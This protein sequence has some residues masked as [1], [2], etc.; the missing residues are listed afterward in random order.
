MKTKSLSNKVLHLDTTFKAQAT[1]EDNGTVKIVGYASTNDLD[2]AG[3][4]ILPEA[5]T[6]S[7]GLDN[8]KKN[9]IIL[10]NH[11]Y[12]KPIGR[13]TAVS[14]TDKGLSIEATISKA[15]GEVVELIKDGVLNAFSVGFMIKDANYDSASDIFVIK[16]AELYETSVVSVPC[17][18]DATFSLAKAFDSEDDFNDYKK[19]FIK[20][21]EPTAEDLAN[22]QNLA[23]KQAEEITPIKENTM[24]PKELEIMLQKVATET[25]EALTKSQAEAA[26]KLAEEKAATEK[27][28]ET[29]NIKVTS[30]AEKLMT[31]I[32]TRFNEKNES[33]ESI[34]SELKEELSAKSEEIVAMRE[35]K[36]EFSDRSGSTDWKKA[37]TEEA[38]DN[39]ILG[40]ATGKGWKTDTAKQ[41]M[42]KVN[43]DSGVEVSSEDFE[44]IVSTN[45]QRD[46]EL[47]LVIAPMF[48]ELPMTS[49]T[50]IMPIMPDAG[51]AEFVSATTTSAAPP[52][53][54]LDE[55][56]VAYGTNAGVDLQER[57][58]S[59]K[60]LMSL[61]YLG[62]ETEEDAILPILPLIREAMVR[63]HA[64]AIENAVL[65]GNHA[66]GAFGTAGASF[67]G[68]VALADADAHQTAISTAFASN[69]VTAA[70]LM[71]MR[72]GMGKYGMRPEDVTYIVSQDAYFDL[73]EDAEF[74]DVNLVGS[75]AVKL[76]GSVGQVYGSSVIVCPE[77]APKALNT[78][79]ALAV[80]TRNFVM[81]RLRGMTIESEYQTVE[82]RRAL[83][84][85][86][87]IGFIDVIDGASAKW[88]L[89]YAAS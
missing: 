57:V 7:K 75:Q 74:A 63:S 48:R 8:F 81:P 79:C 39:F 55:R 23:G 45:I 50:M 84:A 69:V 40:L 80:N 82:Q 34:V 14:V 28:E 19:E 60:K 54:N 58:V 22:A 20:P 36:R 83:V 85:T 66:D 10:F 17:N 2:R 25:A 88:G 64:R 89:Q 24:D 47:E 41:F 53:G 6:T 12:D 73:M 3:D 72:R 37:Y 51:Y 68:L 21:A 9:P 16:D 32:E 27:E 11:N 71:G 49:A 61:S 38:T 1:E 70:D 52:K 13:A 44:Q 30:A 87:R 76:K 43:T 4:V 18:Q 77:F 15:A 62:N 33:L 65:V 56:G 42:Q 35:S 46:I 29:F 67:D 31:D 59:T 86:Q 26:V 78:F 5:W